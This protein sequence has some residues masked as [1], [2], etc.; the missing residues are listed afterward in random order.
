MRIAAIPIATA[1]LGSDGGV[2]DGCARV[3]WRRPAIF[4]VAG[5]GERQF[6]YLR[7]LLKGDLYVYV[8]KVASRGVSLCWGFI[9]SRAQVSG[10]SG[11]PALGRRVGTAAATGLV[12]SPERLGLWG[13]PVARA[14]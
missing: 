7:R 10:G 2:I 11:S 1:D 12:F 8:Q 13:R 14:G 6:V 4:P 5:G 3:H 9:S